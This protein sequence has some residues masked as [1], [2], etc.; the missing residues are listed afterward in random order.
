MRY[1]RSVM[2]LLTRPVLILAIVAVLGAALLPSLTAPAVDAR[3][4]FLFAPGDRFKVNTSTLNVRGGP[5]FS[6]RP[7]RVVSGGTTGTIDRGP[8]F[9]DNYEW[10][11]VVFDDGRPGWVAGHL[12]TKT[13][14]GGVSFPVGARVVTT[15]ALN[16]RTN[17]GLGA[18]IISVLPYGFEALIRGAPVSRDGYTWYPLDNAYEPP[19]AEPMGWVAGEFLR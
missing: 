18:K 4:G 8:R 11:R 6:Y 16:I 9:A 3:S 13:S 17:P 1:L 14:S 7:F 15:T 19:L 12:L 5:G 10:Y 2:S